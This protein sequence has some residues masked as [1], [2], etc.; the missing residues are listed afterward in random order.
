M[1]VLTVAGEGTSTTAT[2]TTL[3]RCRRGFMIVGSS[4]RGCPRSSSRSRRGTP[5]AGGSRRSVIV[6]ML[7]M[8]VG[9]VLSCRSRMLQSGTK[10]TFWCSFNTGTLLLVVDVED[11]VGVVQGVDVEVDVVV[12]SWALQRR[13]L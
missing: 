1:T 8:V 3:S 4:S 11:Q 13:A 2:A 6:R 9:Y 5:R 12:V 7:R 10:L